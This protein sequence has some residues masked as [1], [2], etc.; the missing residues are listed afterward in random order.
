MRSA[1]LMG[2]LRGADFFDCEPT[3]EVEVPPH[4]AWCEAHR[5][6]YRGPWCAKCREDAATLASRGEAERM[7][8][9]AESPKGVARAE[10]MRKINR[11]GVEARLS[12]AAERNARKTHCVRGHAYTPE[13]TGMNRGARYCRECVNDSNRRAYWKRRMA[14]VFGGR[15]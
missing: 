1:A 4:A 2:T 9:E 6:H 5:N 3:P 11:L 8:A 15:P 14:R 7:R 12:G 13:N 10:R